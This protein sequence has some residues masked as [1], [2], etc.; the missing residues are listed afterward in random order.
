MS[1]IKNK[2]K[3]NRTLVPILHFIQKFIQNRTERKVK[4]VQLLKEK[5]GKK[6]LRD[7]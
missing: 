5:R 2:T 4:S 7:A 6:N 3:Q 1:N